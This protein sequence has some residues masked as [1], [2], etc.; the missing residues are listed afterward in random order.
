MC[1]CNFVDTKLLGIKGESDDSG[2]DDE[3]AWVPDRKSHIDRLV[4]QFPPLTDEEIENFLEENADSI[5]ITVDKFRYDFSRLPGH[6]FNKQALYVATRG[7]LKAVKDGAYPKKLPDGQIIPNT[8]FSKESVSDSLKRHFEHLQ[9]LFKE[10]RS[11]HA[12]AKKNSRLASSA[13]KTR[14]MTVSRH[15]SYPQVVSH[16]V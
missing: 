15:H 2:S 16:D 10:A 4:E 8:L 12:E 7:F 11:E 9:R 1:V 13:Q 14:R 6:S 3:E 5:H